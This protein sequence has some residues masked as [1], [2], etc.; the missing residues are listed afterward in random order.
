MNWIVFVCYICKI[1]LFQCKLLFTC[2][3]N[4]FIWDKCCT[5]TDLPSNQMHWFF[6]S[7]W[8]R[9]FFVFIFLH[10][11]HLHR[12]KMNDNSFTDFF[13]HRTLNCVRPKTLK[14]WTEKKKYIYK[15]IGHSS[16]SALHRQMSPDQLNYTDKER[17]G[18]RATLADHK[19]DR[20]KPA[21]H[22]T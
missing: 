14:I 8:F 16:N 15:E 2:F 6:V 20:F 3:K 17:L 9:F 18:L 7:N 10:K 13:S 11:I 4:I 21:K 22:K 12:A 19:S 1:R 5:C